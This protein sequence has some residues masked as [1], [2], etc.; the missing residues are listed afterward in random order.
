MTGP[1]ARAWSS[2]SSPLDA[3]RVPPITIAAGVDSVMSAAVANTFT[4]PTSLRPSPSEDRTESV[5]SFAAN[6]DSEVKRA[7]ASDTAMSECGS[8]KTR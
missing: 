1:I 8:M 2:G 3:S 4:R 7:V 6:V 5:S